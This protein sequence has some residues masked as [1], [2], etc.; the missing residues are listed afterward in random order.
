[1]SAPF[2]S[3]LLK[4]AEEP[5]GAALDAVGARGADAIRAPS[6]PLI[7]NATGAVLTVEDGTAFETLR[8]SLLE[9][10]CSPVQWLGC[11]RTAR[12]A[13]GAGR[14]IELGPGRVLS[15]LWRTEG[16]PCAAFGD[17]D[18]LAAVEVEALC[19]LV[20]GDAEPGAHP[21]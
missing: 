8:A 14:A 13:A 11:M 19:R 12:D 20:E 17:S 9:Q 21:D 5:L 7:S 1:V 6:T 3:A 18:T 16:V 15:S 10:V 2:H 4:G